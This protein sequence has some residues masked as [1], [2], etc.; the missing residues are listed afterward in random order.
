VAED[1]LVGF[2]PDAYNAHTLPAERFLRALATLLFRWR[3]WRGLRRA[4]LRA[5]T[6]IPPGRL[7]DVGGGRGDLGI[8]L[9]RRGW[10]VTSLDPSERACAKARSRG[11]DSACGTLTRP[12]DELGTAYDAI[13]FQH[14][15]EHVVRPA[16]DLAAAHQ[17]L[18]DGG[19]LLVTVPNFAC[20]QRRWFGA[21]WFHLDLPRHRS[22]FTPGGL[23]ALLRGSGLSV[24]EVSISTSSDGLPMSLEYRVL[25]R[26]AAAVASRLAV[27]AVGLLTGPLVAGLN[28]ISGGG[29]ILHAVSTKPQSAGT[30]ASSEVAK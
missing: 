8:V 7:L 3:Y 15:L 24:I 28:T 17:R 5:L 23:E 20:W 2:Y 26:P 21:D 16:A 13:V 10:R 29:D 25:G 4:P 11:V 30:D 14:S 19:I 12:P 1:Q 22:H 27:A 6:G 18:K 9:K